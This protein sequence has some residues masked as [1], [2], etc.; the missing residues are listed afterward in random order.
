VWPAG[1]A[2]DTANDLIVLL[3]PICPGH[4]LKQVL[5]FSVQN[6]IQVTRPWSGVSKAVVRG[7]E[8][9]SSSDRQGVVARYI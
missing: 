6:G 2:A 4:S 5:N 9:D 8:A 1:G 7:G 3:S